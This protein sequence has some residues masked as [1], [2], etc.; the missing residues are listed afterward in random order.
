MEDDKTMTNEELLRNR[1]YFL[2]KELDIQDER[3]RAAIAAAETFLNY[4][5]LLYGYDL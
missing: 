5:R 2:Q 1:V 3:H 4:L